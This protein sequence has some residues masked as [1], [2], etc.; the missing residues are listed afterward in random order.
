MYSVLFYHG[1]AWKLL[2]RTKC[3]THAQAELHDL[4]R[5]GWN[6]RIEE[7]NPTTA[8]FSVSYDRWESAPNGIDRL[9]CC[10]EDYMTLVQANARFSALLSR[11]DIANLRLSINEA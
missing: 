11:E 4:L 9:Q 10:R 8:P 5:M 3:I 6:A 1:N 7:Y 2:L